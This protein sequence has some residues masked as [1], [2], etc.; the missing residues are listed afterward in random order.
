MSVGGWREVP[1][2]ELGRGSRE[3]ARGGNCVMWV[4][5]PERLGGASVR[6]DN[7]VDV[8]VWMAGFSALAANLPHPTDFVSDMRHGDER[9]DPSALKDTF[10]NFPVILPALLRVVRRQSGLVPRDWAAPYWKALNAHHNAPWPAEISFE[11]AE[12]WAWLGT[13]PS[14]VAEVEAFV[15]D[16]MSTP[17][18][19]SALTTLLRR[20][21]TLDIAAAAR[22]TGMSVRTLQ[23][24]LAASSETFASLRNRVRIERAEALLS[25]R[26]LKLDA[27]AATIGF[28]S[29]SHFTAWF[30]RLRGVTPSQFRDAQ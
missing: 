8:R 5:D 30:R 9:T 12:A 15:A 21:P 19:T 25:E 4:Y 20:D 16:V 23:R 10:A 22:S 3:Y 29:T 11:P 2:A 1:S 26:A 28:T 13:D 24:T 14:V 27:I 7:N 18:P 17:D 6:M